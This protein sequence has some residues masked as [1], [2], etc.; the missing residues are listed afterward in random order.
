MLT[1]LIILNKSRGTVISDRVLLAETFGQRLRGLWGLGR[2][3]FPAGSALVIVPC[4]QVHTWFMRFPI[5]V[6]FVDQGGLVL[7]AVPC[8]R[9]YRISPYLKKSRMVIELPPGTIVATGTEENDVINISDRRWE[10]ENTGA[11]AIFHH[12]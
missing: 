4:R 1:D 6:L 10:H 9:P 2:D 12:H 3:D 5:D 7:K 8:L 11:G